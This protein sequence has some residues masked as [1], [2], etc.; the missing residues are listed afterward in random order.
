MCLIF[1]TS[2]TLYFRY[3]FKSVELCGAKIGL[4]DFYQCNNLANAIHAPLWK[5]LTQRHL[6]DGFREAIESE[7]Y[8]VLT[9]RS[10]ITMAE[11]IGARGACAETASQPNEDQQC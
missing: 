2:R 11:D 4:L 8:L 5:D 9:L 7:R 10:F 1:C 6:R 3:W